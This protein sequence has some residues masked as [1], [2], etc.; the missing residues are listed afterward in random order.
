MNIYKVSYTDYIQAESL[1]QA[2]DILLEQLSMDVRNDDA[3]AFEFEFEGVTI[4]DRNK[5]PCGRFDLTPEE[6]KD[7]Y[8]E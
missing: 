4:T 1:E 2:Q 5:S 6:S 8:G 7:L 3:E